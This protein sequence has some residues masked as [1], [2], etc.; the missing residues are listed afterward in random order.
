[1]L[2]INKLVDVVYHYDVAFYP[3][4]PKK[5]MTPAF[6]E[7]A[8]KNLPKI[9]IAFDG[10]ASAYADRVLPEKQLEAEVTII[11]PQTSR[12]KTFKVTLKQ[13]KHSEILLKKALTT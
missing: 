12:E 7:F 1:M 4:K 10:R 2:N 11:H 9:N 5:L 13:A 6:L 8:K 3:D